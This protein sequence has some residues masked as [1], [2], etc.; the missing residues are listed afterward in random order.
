MC[1]KCRKKEIKVKVITEQEKIPFRFKTMGKII[2][3]LDF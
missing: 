3:F 2:G 1:W